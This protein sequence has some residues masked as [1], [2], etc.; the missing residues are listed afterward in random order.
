MIFEPIDVSGTNIAQLPVKYKKPEPGERFL[1]PVDPGKCGHWQGPFEI[2]VKG[3]KCTCKRCGEEVS[4]M[5]VLEQ[6]MNTES[7]WM[8]ANAQYQDEMRR[9]AE[10]SRTKCNHCGKMTGIS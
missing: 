4:A 2:D 10:R 7:R 1:V 6:L 9:L 3:G 5:Y 8:Q